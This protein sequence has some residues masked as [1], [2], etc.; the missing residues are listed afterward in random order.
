MLELTHSPGSFRD[1]T[2]F[3]FER[4]GRLYRQI[5]RRGQSDFE[6]LMGSGLYDGLAGEGMLIPHRDA[7]VEPS[8]DGD[9]YL[10][11]EPERVPFV[12][13]PYEWCF[14]QLRDAALLTLEVHR[15][16]LERGMALKDASAYNVQFLG[17]RPAFIDTLSFEAYE[18]GETWVA[19]RQFC[20]HF[21]APLALM[22]TTDVRLGQLLRTY[23]D[24]VPLDL[25]SRLLPARTRLRPGLLFHL[26]FHARIQKD[27]GSR[28]RPAGKRGGFGRGAMLGL[29]ENLASVVRGLRWDPPGEGWAGYYEDNTYSP[30]ATEQKGRF[31]ASALD[32]AGPGTVWDL[33]AN[34]GHYSRVA[35]GRGAMAVAFDADPACVE[36]NYREACRKGESR[37][38]PLLLDLTNPSPDSGWAN[39][40]RM[41][42]LARGPAHVAL[43]LALVHHLAISANV[44]LALIADFFRRACQWLVIEFVPKGDPQVERLLASRKDV[45]DQYHKAEFENAFGRHFDV[46]STERV[47]GTDRDL[48]LMHRRGNS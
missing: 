4:G 35:A 38:L 20:Q 15:R 7:D 36:R 42:L 26:H 33:G 39:H 5:N 6:R 46:V 21:L 17:S 30:V 44:P 22:S 25:A 24:G 16:A 14:G 41:S 19:Y 10:V 32:R 23:L 9:G 3:V 13:Y 37:V 18:E 12:S 40:E 27:A 29:I 47:E 48:Y 45:F 11:I 34:T 31:V 28:S 1:P 2:G 43:A 8:G